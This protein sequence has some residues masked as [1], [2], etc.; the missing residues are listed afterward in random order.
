MKISGAI[1]QQRNII[2]SSE[3]E[4]QAT[5]KGKEIYISTEH[6]LGK[7]EFDHLIRFNIDVQDLKTGMYDV[8]TYQDFHEINDAIR[9]ALKGA[10]LIS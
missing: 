1:I 5:Y 2:V 9:Y 7:P 3:N 4:F 6:S 8:Q 10:C